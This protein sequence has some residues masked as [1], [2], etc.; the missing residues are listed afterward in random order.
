MVAAGTAYLYG[1]DVTIF[2]SMPFLGKKLAITGKGRCN[3]T[4]ASP[5]QELLENITKNPRFLYS[6]LSTFTPEDAMSTF[7]NLGV[8]LKVERGNRVY[9]TSDKARDIVDAMRK[10]CEGATVI[11]E[12]VKKVFANNDGGF[13]V[14]TDKDYHFDR[15]II[16]TGGK[17]YPLTG[18]DGSGYRLATSLGHSVT[19]LI[20]S[21]I[22]ISSPSRLCPDMQGLSLKN[23]AIKV[24]DQ[25]ENVL[26]TDF[27]EMMFTHFG[28]TGPMILS[29]SAH[30]RAYDI[31]T[32]TLSI[33]LKP[34]LDEKTLDA[35]LLSDF[36]ANTNKDFINSLSALLP[37]KMIEPFISLTGIDER[38]KINAITKEERKTI[39]TT[40]KDFRIPLSALRPIEEA[41]VTSGGV[42]VKEINPKT[43]ESKIKPGLYFAGEVIDVD[44]YTGGFNLQI[45][46]STGYLA[47][48]SAAESCY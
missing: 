15:V 14:K 26:Y 22:P 12:K 3:V 42:E 33:D 7:E 13:T 2:E 29:A 1:A 48:K 47:G 8:P 40:L 17:S 27:G 43:M 32:L 41:I 9:P 18:S 10:Y 34:A 45:A 25:N 46:Y 36:K 39:L 30:L 20:P 4:N 44:A 23:V 6:A 5:I 19:E 28:V 24:L 38:K 11:H 16:A 21:L 37:S 31:S 35:R